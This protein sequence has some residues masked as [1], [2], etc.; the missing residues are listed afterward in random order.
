MSIKRLAL[1]SGILLYCC[2]ASAAALKEPGSA[3][4]DNPSSSGSSVVS[5]TDEVA[6]RLGRNHFMLGHGSPPSDGWLE[7]TRK[8]GA[9]WDLRYQYV[10][11]DCNTGNNWKT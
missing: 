2:L 8:Q 7:E 1:A 11:G 10:C 4:S 3:K 5:K 9:S 6:R